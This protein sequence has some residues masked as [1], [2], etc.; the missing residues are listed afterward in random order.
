[1][2]DSVHNELA[3]LFLLFYTF[4]IKLSET[5]EIALLFLI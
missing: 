3:A 5:V 4:I 1:M 2:H